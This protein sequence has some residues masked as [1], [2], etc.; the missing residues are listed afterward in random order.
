MGGGYTG[1]SNITSVFK[2]SE[3][4]FMSQNKYSE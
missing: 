3:I 2:F 4:D 1:A